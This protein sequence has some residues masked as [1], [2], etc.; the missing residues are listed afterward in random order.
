MIEIGAGALQNDNKQ[1]HQQQGMIVENEWKFVIQFE[2]EK[3]SSF[4]CVSTHTHFNL[5]GHTKSQY[6]KHWKF[7][8]ANQQQR[9]KKRL[10]PY[11]QKVGWTIYFF[12][13]FHWRMVYFWYGVFYVCVCV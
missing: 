1:Q 10:K 5:C 7:E 13:F 3:R 11:N 2:R 9:W 12:L 6:W 8:Q 4:M